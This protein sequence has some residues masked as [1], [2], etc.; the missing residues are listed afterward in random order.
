MSFAAA[1]QADTT[2]N[3]GA[4]PG[5]AWSS[6]GNWSDGAPDS[7]DTAYFTNT[8][9]STYSVNVDTAAQAN[10]LLASQAYTF[11]GS[12]SVT[13]V[14]NDTTGYLI[15]T[16]RSELS[17][18]ELT[19]NTG[20]TIN[21]QGTAGATEIYNLNAGSSIVFNNGLTHTGYSYLNLSG[22][23]TIVINGDLSVADRIRFGNTVAGLNVIIGGTG[24]TSSSTKWTFARAANL[25]LNRAGA[26]AT[27][28]QLL[29]MEKTMVYLGA[30]N[31]VASGTDVQMRDSGGTGGITAQG[32][33]QDF[34]GLTI[35]A[36]ALF[37]M[38]GSDSVWTFEDSSA[39]SWT[40]GTLLDI[41]NAENAVIRF[42]IDGGTG[43][44][45]S[46]IGQIALDGTV[47][48]SADTA[49][50]H[51]YLYITRKKGAIKLILFSNQ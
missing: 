28:D 21:H 23:G 29:D 47:L 1:V 16:L 22:L 8:Q 18:G 49:V 11:G 12:G 32:Y 35:A 26:Y 43:L 14:R 27:D 39:L 13:L 4:V 15:Q 17:S 36:D 2:W 38:D 44:T 34:G 25:Y 30:D 42:A 10:K 33:D 3:G 31:A 24:T 20:V 46:Q 51:N 48:T 7:A 9:T 40:A 6:A 37:D 19:F 41:T 5:A 45:E 50:L